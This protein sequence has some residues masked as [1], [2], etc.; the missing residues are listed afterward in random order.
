MKEHWQ[1]A[2]RENTCNSEN[3]D[4]FFLK[5]P[6]LLKVATESGPLSSALYFQLT[7]TFS[8]PLSPQAV[9]FRNKPHLCTS[10][11]FQIPRASRISPDSKSW[12]KQKRNWLGVKCNPEGPAHQ[13]CYPEP[14]SQAHSVL[15]VMVWW[16]EGEKPA[17]W[18]CPQR[19][20]TEY[21]VRQIW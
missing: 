14:M 3:Y 16:P 9:I 21:L 12:R 6:Y 13:H 10:H 2:E 15:G 18:F 7:L 1:T 11:I 4:D 20:T 17:N 5:P 8:S 19:S